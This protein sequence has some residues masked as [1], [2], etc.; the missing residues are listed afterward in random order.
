VRRALAPRAAVPVSP[1]SAVGRLFHGGEPT[2][3]SPPAARR[4][5]ADR[6]F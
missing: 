2:P 5:G 6:R 3:S 4:I 1:R